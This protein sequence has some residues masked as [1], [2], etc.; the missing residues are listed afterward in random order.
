M[1]HEPIRQPRQAQHGVRA[2]HPREAHE[3]F[4]AHVQRGLQ[5]AWNRLQHPGVTPASEDG[6]LWRGGVRNAAAACAVSV[7]V[8]DCARQRSLQISRFGRGRLKR[9][10]RP[11]EARADHGAA[12]AVRHARADLR[13]RRG[14]GYGRHDVSGE[15]RWATRRKPADAAGRAGRASLPTGTVGLQHVHRRVLELRRELRRL[16]EHVCTRWNRGAEVRCGGDKVC[17]RALGLIEAF[18]EGSDID[19]RAGVH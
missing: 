1:Q 17:Q 13:G 14:E 2:H 6:A 12:L 5:P 11:L 19:G 10:K 18:G 8:L 7:A 15:G 16:G 3:K 4:V 9:R